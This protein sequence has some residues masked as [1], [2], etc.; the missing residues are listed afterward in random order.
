MNF[1]KDPVIRKRV[2]TMA[3]EI[4]DKC[5]VE[6]DRADSMELTDA[7]RKAIDRCVVKY[8]ETAKYVKEVFATALAAV[9][10]VQNRH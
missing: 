8:L 4:Y 3:T 6:P 10:G 9:Y 5:A 7:E 1:P 2:M